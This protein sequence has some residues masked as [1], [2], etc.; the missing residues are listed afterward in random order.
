MDR[1]WEE[2]R[3]DFTHVDSMSSPL[4]DTESRN[5]VEM[6]EGCRDLS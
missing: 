1:N 2:E 5:Q 6:K 4:I 3:G